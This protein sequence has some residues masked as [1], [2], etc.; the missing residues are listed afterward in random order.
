MTHDALCPTPGLLNRS[1]KVDGRCGVRFPQRVPASQGINALAF[2]FINIAMANLTQQ[3]FGFQQDLTDGLD[4]LAADLENIT[5]DELQEFIGNLPSTEAGIETPF[6]SFHVDNVPVYE[7]PVDFPTDF[8]QVRPIETQPETMR[9]YSAFGV[10][11]NERDDW[12][13]ISLVLIVAVL[14]YVL[15]A[16]IDYWYALKLEKAKRNL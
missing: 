15:K 16:Q 7:L 10:T 11:V 2:L 13:T 9:E 8:N 1:L 14:A 5:E 6:G 4:E 3:Q 12:I